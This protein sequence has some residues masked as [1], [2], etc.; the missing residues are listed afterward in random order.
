LLGLLVIATVARIVS[1]DLPLQKK[2]LH[3]GDKILKSEG[4][5]ISVSPIMRNA[6]L[7][8]LRTSCGTAP[9]NTHAHTWAWE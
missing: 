3:L 9:P 6:R 5:V 1:R 7:L 4:E 8:T 2:Y